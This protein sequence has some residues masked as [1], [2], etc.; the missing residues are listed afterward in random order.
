M[1]AIFFVLCLCNEPYDRK[2]I[3]CKIK[4][5]KPTHIAASILDISKILLYDFHY[6]NRAT[7]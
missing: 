3:K 5:N 2:K 6:G 7:L 4:P 1:I